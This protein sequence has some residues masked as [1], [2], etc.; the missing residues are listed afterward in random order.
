MINVALEFFLILLFEDE[1]CHGSIYLQGR[2][3][4]QAYCDVYA[5]NYANDV[6]DRFGKQSTLC[7]SHVQYANSD[8]Y[9]VTVM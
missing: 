3:I 5:K 1:N 2:L 8:W 4:G 6:Y 7:Q 9:F